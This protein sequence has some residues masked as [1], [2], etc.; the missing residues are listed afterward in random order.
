MIR[1]RLNN[2]RGNIDHG[3]L[4]TYHTFSFGEYYDPDHH[5]FSV[6]RVLNEDFLEPGEGG[7]PMHPHRNMEIIT[8]I[9][10]GALRHQDSLGNIQIIQPGEVQ[11]MCAGRGIVHSEHNASLEHKIQMFQIW[12][13]PNQNNLTP[14]YV[15]QYFAPE[16]KQNKWCLIA[17]SSGKDHSI[18]VN[19]D[20]QLFNSLLSTEQQLTYELTHK[21]CAY[22]HLIKG[23]IF[24]N[25]VELR[26]GDGAYIEAEEALKIVSLHE[27]EIL[28]F[29]LPVIQKK[30]F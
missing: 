8:Y 26:S 27:S 4:N 6:L 13:Q 29:D 25:Q 30:S 20:I 10:Q 5:E 14:H 22:L 23:Q 1:I 9:A 28:L 16:K 3:W 11:Y 18:Q 17:S 12:I 24:L 7:F 2:E 19:Q 15:K 21:R